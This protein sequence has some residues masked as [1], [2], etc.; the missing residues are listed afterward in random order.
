MSDEPPCDPVVDSV[1]RKIETYIAGNEEFNFFG[2]RV[3]D[4]DDLLHFIALVRQAARC[5]PSS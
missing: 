3:L 1:L 5:S 2:Q 4:S